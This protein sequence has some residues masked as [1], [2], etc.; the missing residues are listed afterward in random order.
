MVIYFGADHRGF[1]LKEKLKDFLKNRGYEV[2]DLG[3]LEYDESDDYPD[4]ASAVAEKVNI[5]Y[6]NSRGILICG[7]GVGMDIV[8]NKFPNIR[9]V[10]AL[11]SDQV[12]DSRTHNDTNILTL[13][14]DY[15]DEEPALKI[16][17]AWL[18]TPFSGEERYVRRLKKISALELEL[19]DE[20]DSLRLEKDAGL[21]DE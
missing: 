19:F 16:T 9:S 8:A 5:D 1:Q 14:S 2:V 7:S 21:I 15:L 17:E 20:K 12:Y 18:G 3:N 11:N 6:E 4:F 10:L 13:A